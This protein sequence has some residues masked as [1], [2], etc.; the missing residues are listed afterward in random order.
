[1]MMMM[2]K[3]LYSCIWQQLASKGLIQ[4]LMWI[5]WLSGLK[6]AETCTEVSIPRSPSI[7]YKNAYNKSDN[8]W[9]A[10]TMSDVASELADCTIVQLRAVRSNE[11]DKCVSTKSRIRS[12]IM[13][14]RQM[15]IH[16]S[17]SRNILGI[18]LCE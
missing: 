10:T 7:Q 6:G 17:L 3:M 11:L 5:N 9:H 12:I 14:F 18:R 2:H 16:Q 1:M 15:L 8:V 13:R 4:S